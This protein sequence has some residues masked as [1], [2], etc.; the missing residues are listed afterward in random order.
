MQQVSVSIQGC[1]CRD[2]GGV[3]KEMENRRQAAQA[4]FAALA[5][6][7]E[8]ASAAAA[9]SGALESALQN[10]EQQAGISWWG[11]NHTL[12]RQPSKKK[13]SKPG[14]TC[15]CAFATKRAFLAAISFG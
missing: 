1:P 11:W 2:D 3:D 9:A 4:V 10:A 13:G 7:E 15:C 12:F 8:A 5:D 14:G 6:A